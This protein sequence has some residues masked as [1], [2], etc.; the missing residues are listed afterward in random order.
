MKKISYCIKNSFI[1]KDYFLM[2]FQDFKKIINSK[3]LWIVL[4]KIPALPASSPLFLL[5]MK[6]GELTNATCS[7]TALAKIS[8]WRISACIFY[9]DHL[10]NIQYFNNCTRC[11]SNWSAVSRSLLLSMRWA[12]MYYGWW[13]GTQPPCHEAASTM[14]IFYSLKKPYSNKLLDC[15]SL[16]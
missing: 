9:N 12:K 3:I 7:L 1:N 16:K 15:H 2:N 13:Y 8:V 4:V 10:K 6:L 11:T 14:H 5:T